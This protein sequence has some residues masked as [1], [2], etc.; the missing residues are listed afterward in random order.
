[1][2]RFTSGE[3]PTAQTAL[4]AQAPPEAGTSFIELRN[5]SK[6][7]NTPS[8]S[9][10]AVEAATIGLRHGET[11]ALLGPSGC[12]KSTLLMIIAGL[13]EPTSGEVLI[14]DREIRGVRP[15]LGLVFQRD[16][17]VDWKTVLGNVLLPFDLTGGDRERNIPQAQALLERVGLK[18]FEQKRPYE[19]SGGMRQRVAICRALIQNPNILLLDEPFAALDAFTR[20]QMQLDVQRLSLDKPRTTIL[21]THEIS[22]A[23]FMADKIAVMTAR[24]GRIH[25]L[26][27]VKLERPRDLE[28]RENPA[29]SDYVTKIH[30]LFAQL[31]VLHG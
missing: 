11:L 29:F 24:P 21:V 18:G 12:G 8:G 22:E 14:E 19:L 17:L 15:D 31:G 20:E 6:T 30:R 23:V 13:L 25:T 5:V 9:V 3:N 7:F 1:L 16:L 2:S 26:I 4:G 27:D 28:S 10:T